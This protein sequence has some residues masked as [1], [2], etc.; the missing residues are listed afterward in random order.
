MISEVISEG[1]SDGISEGISQE[2]GGCEGQRRGERAALAVAGECE[3]L[4]DAQGARVGIEDMSHE[5]QPRHL[6]RVRVRARVG[7]RARVGVGARVGGEG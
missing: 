7:A 5:L 3:L 4:R 1:I 6:V 2:G